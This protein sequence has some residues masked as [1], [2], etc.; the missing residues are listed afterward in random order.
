MAAFAIRPDSQ[1]SNKEKSICVIET[2]PS[3]Q[4]KPLRCVS[5]FSLC[6]RVP[7]RSL[8][9]DCDGRRQHRARDRT[10]LGVSPDQLH[11]GPSRRRLCSGPAPRQSVGHLNDGLEPVLGGEQRHQHHP[12]Y[13][14]GCRR[15]PNRTDPAMPSSNQEVS[16]REPSRLNTRDFV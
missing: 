16:P 1:G 14:R 10:R 3:R 7:H 15:Q 5:A 8:A 6:F 12:T 11:L 4:K 2:A 9:P 13:P